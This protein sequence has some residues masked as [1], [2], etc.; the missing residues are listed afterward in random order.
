M[1]RK[2]QYDIQV[3]KIGEF[4]RRIERGFYKLNNN[5]EKGKLVNAAI[6]WKLAKSLETEISNSGKY[7]DSLTSRIN[8]VKKKC[9]DLVSRAATIRDNSIMCGSESL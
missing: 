6:I 7:H 2:K 4:E 8:D 3:E 1:E 9:A 5:P